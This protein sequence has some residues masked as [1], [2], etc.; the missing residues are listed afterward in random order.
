[1]SVLGI[2]PLGGKCVSFV[3][4]VNAPESI[5]EIELELMLLLRLTWCCWQRNADICLFH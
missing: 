4:L 5:D 3:R 2:V 1:M